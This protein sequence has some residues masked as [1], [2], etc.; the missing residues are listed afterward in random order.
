MDEEERVKKL[1]ELLDSEKG[2]LILP[3]LLMSIF[4]PREELDKIFNDFKKKLREGK[5]EPDG[6]TKNMSGFFFE[7]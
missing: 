6:Q 4:T 1:K 5:E 7:E 3:F 2:T